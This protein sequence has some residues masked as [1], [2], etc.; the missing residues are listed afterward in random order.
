MLQIESIDSDTFELLQKL[1]EQNEL[2]HFALAGGTA[3]AL[4]LGHRISVD[5]DFFTHSTFDSNVLLEQLEDQFETENSSASRNSLSLFIK[6]HR[7]SVKV[8]FVRHNYPL[9][10]PIESV[11]GVRLFSLK[12]IAAM[13]L[14]AIAN[15][16]AKKDFYDVHA[17][18]SHFSLNDLLRFFE[19]KYQRRNSFTVIKSLTYFEDADMD[20]EPISLLDISWE[21]IKSGIRMK[22]RES[23]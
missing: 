2:T 7:S 5:L 16:G 23:F 15:R 8:D 19:E 20:P 6:S 13:K 9:L 11:E 14:N 22:L 18:L 17:L 21:T 1:S 3:L 4:R 12:D 10:A